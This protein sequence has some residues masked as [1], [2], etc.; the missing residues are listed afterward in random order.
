MQVKQ[1]DEDKCF[2]F[3]I[4]VGEC[5]LYQGSLLMRTFDKQNPDN[6]HFVNLK[7]GK[8]GSFSIDSTKPIYVIPVDSFVTYKVKRSDKGADNEDS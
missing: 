1:E 4:P 3:S 6:V 7:T 2:C 5:F 8:F